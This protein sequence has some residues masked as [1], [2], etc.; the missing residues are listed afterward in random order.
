MLSVAVCPNFLVAG[1][2]AHNNR[3]MATWPHGH[4]HTATKTF[5]GGCMQGHINNNGNGKFKKQKNLYYF[6]ACHVT[7][8]TSMGLWSIRA[9]VPSGRRPRG[10]ECVIQEIGQRSKPNQTKQNKTNPKQSKTNQI[11]PKQRK[12][13]AGVG[14]SCAYCRGRCLETICASSAVGGACWR[15]DRANTAEGKLLEWASLTTLTKWRS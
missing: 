2:R 5:F 10:R 11:K 1:C 14:C 8:P 13:A 12:Q 3:Y 7:D 6:I 9:E 4:M 15:L